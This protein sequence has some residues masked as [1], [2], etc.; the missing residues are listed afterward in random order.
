[1]S[2]SPLRFPRRA[3]LAAVL[4]AASAA[5]VHGQTHAARVDDFG[6]VH[7]EP[8]VLPGLYLVRMHAAPAVARSRVPMAR[9]AEARRLAGEQDAVLARVGRQTGTDLR[10]LSETFRFVHAANAV[11]VRMDARAAAALRRAPEVAAVEP[12]VL[13]PLDTDAGPELIGAPE[14]W[15]VRYEK[16]PR[17]PQLVPVPIRGARR[18]ADAQG[19][20]TVIGVIDSGLNFGSPSFAEVDGAGYRHRNP[21]GEGNYLGLCGPDPIAA[22]APRCNGKVIGAYDF[23]DELMPTIRENDPG[24]D[25]GPPGPEDNNGHGSHTASIAAGNVRLARVPGGPERLVSGVAPRAN[26]VVY[27]TCYVAGDGRGLCPNVSTLAAVEQ[28]IVDGVVTAINYSI[29]GGTS[30]WTQAGSLAFLDALE[31]GISVVA[32]TGN[33]GPS[34]ATLGH[35]EPWTLSVAAASHTRGPFAN[36]LRITGPA[37]VPAP[38][39]AIDITFPASSTPLIEPIAGGLAYDP[40]DPLLCTPPAPGSMAGRVAMARRGDCTFVIKVENAQIGGASAVILANN[41]DGALNPAL[42]GTVIPVGVVG[43][44][45]GDRL[46]DFHVERGEAQVLLDYPAEARASEPDVIATFSSRGPSGYALL[47]PD[48]TAPGVSVLGAVAGEPGAIGLMNGTSMASPHVAGAVALLRAR[49]P[50][51]TP[52]EAKSALMLTATE[53]VLDAADGL[54][55]TP[56]ER[57]AGR[58]RLDLAVEPGLVMDETAARFRAADPAQGGDPS[59][60]NLPSIGALSCIGTCTFER[61]VRAVSAGQWSAELDGIAGSVTPSRFTL[62]AGQSQTLTIVIDAAGAEQGAHAYGAVRLTPASVLLPPLQMPVAVH[63]DAMALEVGPDHIEASAPAGGRAQATLELGNAGNDG[64]GWSLYSGVRAVPAIDQP[65]TTLNGLVSTQYADTGTGALVADDFELSVE[66][67][68][69]TLSVDGFLFANYGD[70]LD[71]YAS[72]LTWSIHADADGRPAGA[73]G[74]GEAPVWSFTA[75]PGTP[76]VA[77]GTTRMDLDL[78]EAGQSLVLPPGR[79]WLVAYPT[80][81]S[82]SVGGVPMV[83]WYRFLRDV[84]DGLVGQELNTDPEFGGSP[85]ATWGPLDGAS[86]GHYGAAMTAL[87]EGICTPPWLSAAE[88]AGSLAAG[89]SKSVALTLDAAALEPGTHTGRLC[90]ES[91][92]PARPL[93][94]VPVTFRVG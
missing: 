14:T 23:V 43:R 33:S 60:L 47:K 93:T 38:L 39:Q 52:A 27:D 53:E 54:P 83:I 1:M 61:T 78:V 73:P 63:V 74:Q 81:D 5:P 9:A 16:S 62:R 77:G 24:A 88:T 37:P 41:V 51:W 28:S 57:G 86:S 68:F 11:T 89:Q 20:G 85:D 29:G 45:D 19:E 34:S 18:V 17:S 94:V 13:L 32:S 2:Q 58:I 50:D 46:H 42:D 6:A 22:W 3:A 87:A 65:A 44:A 40:Q 90:V 67:A 75:A 71:M 26:L 69:E 66:T 91:N 10:P 79:Y 55:A 70:T 4:A 84:Q 8:E 25:D 48:A 21:L 64:L 36:A 56:H 76:G 30:P 59:A 49:H 35:V 31:A 12:V 80:F 92:D 7:A 82:L 15:G 72:A